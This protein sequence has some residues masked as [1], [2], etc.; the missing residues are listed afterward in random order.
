MQ[1]Q[2]N[3]RVVEMLRYLYQHTDENHPATVTD[4]TAYL[5]ERGIQAVRQT[6]YA[7][8]NA[9]IAAGFDI[10]VVKSTQNQYF[11]GSRI[12]EYPE[13]KMLV[14]AV[15]ASKT[16]S[17]KKSEQLIQK[18]C[19]LAS[20]MQAAHLHQ[21]ASLS[22]RIKPCNEKVYYIVDRLQTAILEHRQV[23]FQYYEYT[24]EKQKIL[25]HDGYRY[26]LDP[27]ALEWKNDHYYLIG[28]SHKHQSMAHFRVDRLAGV[29]LL[30]TKFQP[31]DDFDAAA[32]TN[33]LVEMFAA[34]DATRVELLCDNELMRVIVDHYGE[35]VPVVPFDESHFIATIEVSPSNTFYGWVFKFDGK[36]KIISPQKCVD[37]MRQIALN[38]L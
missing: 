33:K 14:D 36:M 25:K 17:P 37:E 20:E 6:V 2:G 18:L 38:F 27:Y 12:F 29:E 4:I 1:S 24:R 7:D 26:I 34:E 11:I 16:I 30:E 8:L 9:L 5:K 23:E 32:Y 3:I 28:Y 21:L 22:S 13:L 10:V 19:V 15:A 31:P 35:T